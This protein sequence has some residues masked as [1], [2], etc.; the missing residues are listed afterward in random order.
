LI[1][2]KYALLLSTCFILLL[3]ASCTQD[4]C[5]GKYTYRRYTP[6][7]KPFSEIKSMIKAG[8]AISIKTP[9][10]IY[11]WGKYLFI[12]E[13]DKGI[14]VIDNSNPASPRIVSFINIPGNIDMAVKG[15]TLLADCYTG[16]VAIDVSNPTVA[17]VIS[18]TENALPKQQSTIAQLDPTKGIC[19]GYDS[20]TVVED[21][22]YPNC[23]GNRGRFATD[24][25]FYASGEFNTTG[26]AL[27]STNTS[28]PNTIGKAGS[29]ARFAVVGNTLYIVNNTSL[30]IYDVS[31]VGTPVHIADK[32]IGWSIETIFPDKN[33]LYIG[34]TTGMY[35]YDVSQPQSPTQ[36]GVFSHSLGCD[37]VV[38]SGNYAYVTIRGGTPCHQSSTNS[39]FAIDIS[40]PANPQQL[41]EYTLTNPTGLG[42]DGT[43]LFVCDG[44]DGLK[45][46]DAADPKAISSHKLGQFTNMLYNDVIPMGKTLLAIGIDGLYEYDYTNPKQIYQLSHIPIFGK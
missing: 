18:V 37:P 9:G 44:G 40:N 25:V 31:N 45:V 39:L 22:K 26:G 34:S 21:L 1:M 24:D 20:T 16:L 7:Y 42:I 3:L 38:V 12:N 43:T 14:H 29:T 15:N 2:K 6:V 17:S 32:A 46:Y 8:A 4:T 33:R 19:I 36:L 5:T 11:V 35:I 13:V 41:A 30:I 23:G 28:T 27:K 10:K